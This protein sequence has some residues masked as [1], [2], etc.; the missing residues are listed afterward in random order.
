MCVTDLQKYEIASDDEDQLPFRCFI[1]RESFVNPVVTKY[2]D[3]FFAVVDTENFV[4]F[5][6]TLITNFDL[7]LV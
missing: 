1:C 4:F 2:A 6:L 3:S 7:R 5:G